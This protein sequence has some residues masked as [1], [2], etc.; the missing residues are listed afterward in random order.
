VVVIIWVFLRVLVLQHGHGSSH[1]DAFVVE[2]IRKARGV[3]EV[4]KRGKHQRDEDYHGTLFAND[5]KQYAKAGKWK[6]Y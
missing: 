5:G 4:R 2:Q 1:I 3:P 6:S